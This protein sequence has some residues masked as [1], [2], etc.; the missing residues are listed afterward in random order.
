MVQPD[1]HKTLAV[2]RSEW[3]NCTDCA[4]GERRL[5]VGG[6]FVFGR[7]ASRGILF[8]WEGPGAE[9]EKYGA[10]FIGRSGELLGRVLDR[11]GCQQYYLTNLVSC[12][13][14]APV[15][16]A[17]GNPRMRKNWTTKS[18][19]QV[20]Q[21]EPPTPPQCEACLPRLYEEIYLVDPVLIV[22]L[23]GKAAEVLLRKSVTITQTHGEATQI[24]IPGHGF[25]ASL[26]D[27]RREWVR[28]VKGEYIQPTEQNKVYYHFIPTF[29]PAY[30]ARHLKDDRITS[31]FRL[32]V[33][34]LHK[35]L[36]TYETYMELA[37]G[38]VPSEREQDNAV[39][40]E[41]LQ[42][43]LKGDDE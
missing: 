9:E 40:Y 23:G 30:V 14:C 41:K 28:K 6:K 10:P 5:A 33:R 11:L 38:V 31:P 35:A 21:D 15:T 18:L 12:R 42:A 36:K 17:E 2:L 13:S 27:K 29:H 7:G 4:L 34:D 8:V 32:F 43:E 22:G 16:D 20:Y 37:F 26:T 1:A 25:R 39:F 3:E 19:E 24:H